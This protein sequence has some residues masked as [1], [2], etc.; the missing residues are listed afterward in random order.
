MTTSCYDI[1]FVINI[2]Q[3]YSLIIETDYFNVDPLMLMLFYKC[4]SHISLLL[5]EHI[6]VNGIN[7]TNIHNSIFVT[8]TI[9]GAWTSR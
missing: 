4:I 9:D 5:I 3:N 2:A 8:N 7:M 1:I 6:L